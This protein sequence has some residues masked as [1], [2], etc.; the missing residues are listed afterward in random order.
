MLAKFEGALAHAGIRLLKN[1]PVQSIERNED[2]LLISMATGEK[3]LFDRVIVTVPSPVA[4]KICCRLSDSELE[5]HQQVQ[6]SG[7]ICASVLIKSRLSPYYVTN[8]L[9]ETI[10]FTG[11]IEMSALVDSSELKGHGLLYIPRYLRPEHSDFQRTDEDLKAEMLT[12]LK[13]MHPSMTEE[14]VIAFRISRARYVFAR[15]TLGYSEKLPPIDTS[16][17]GLSIVNSSHVVN[18]TLN[19]NETVA[20]AVREALRIHASQN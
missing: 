4:A 19:A 3:L 2:K 20:L 5:K 14:D 10:P 11:L 13:R 17:Q 18:G 6:Y 1:A 7:I 12:S 15:P 8:I 16:V 9:D